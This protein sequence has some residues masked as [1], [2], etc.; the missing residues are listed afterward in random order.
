MIVLQSRK[1]KFDCFV[2]RTIW[3]HLYNVD[4]RHFV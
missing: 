3:Q 1:H 4:Q 2:I